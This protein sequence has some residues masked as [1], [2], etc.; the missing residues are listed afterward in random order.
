[1]TI[2]LPAKFI[3]FILCVVLTSHSLLA[4]SYDYNRDYKHEQKINNEE[5]YFI[6]TALATAITLGSLYVYSQKTLDVLNPGLLSLGG[7]AYLTLGSDTLYLTS[8]FYGAGYLD[9][10]FANI[11]YG[12]LFNPAWLLRLIGSTITL[13]KFVYN[14]FSDNALDLFQDS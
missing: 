10:I 6:H 2:K 7:V 5:L 12:C 8:A 1:M 9:D 13:G 11:P 3:K 4:K 14:K